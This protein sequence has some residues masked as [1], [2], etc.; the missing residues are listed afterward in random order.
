MYQLHTDS[1][2]SV[3]QSIVTGYSALIL[4]TAIAVL[5]MDDDDERNDAYMPLWRNV[6]QT[7][8]ATF[9]HDQDG[10]LS[11][12]LPSKITSRLTQQPQPRILQQPKTLNPNHHHPPLPTL[13]A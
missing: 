1:H 12:S 11:S 3:S 10:K 2:S 4:D 8:H 9:E 13:Q 7:L 5:Q 6:V